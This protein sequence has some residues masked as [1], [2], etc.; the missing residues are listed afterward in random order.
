MKQ[1]YS[2]LI[3]LLSILVFSIPAFAA[4]SG[5]LSMEAMQA[6]QEGNLDKIHAVAQKI[7]SANPEDPYGYQLEAKYY[8]RIKNYEEAIKYYTKVIAK[9]KSVK[10]H[11]SIELR[12][13]GLSE[14]MINQ[15]L[16]FDSSIAKAYNLR[17]LCYFNQEKS[18][19]A[20]NDFINAEKYEKERD[21]TITYA[22]SL[23]LMDLGRF[24]DA[25]VSLNL[26]KKLASD[27]EEVETIEKLLQVA[28]QRKNGN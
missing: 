20:L 18:A 2:K 28:N 4:V 7:I 16:N 1:F 15:V 19:E 26:A 13:R 22:K 5:V 8:H 10:E 6:E 23:C 9:A 11:D 3:L 17:G 24:N 27:Q 14:E 25:I 12:Q 21:Y